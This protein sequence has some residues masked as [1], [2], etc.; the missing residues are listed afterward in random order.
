VLEA[1]RQPLVNVPHVRQ[2]LAGLGQDPAL[3]LALLPLTPSSAR[4]SGVAAVRKEFAELHNPVVDVVSPPPLYF[5]VSRPPRPYLVLLV[6]LAR[7]LVNRKRSSS[8]KLI[9][10][11][12]NLN[13]FLNN[14]I[15]YT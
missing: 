14:F 4:V 2:E 11:K 10:G 1:V 7:N 8:M 5:I 12:G 13:T 3:G 15:H 6:I 9:K